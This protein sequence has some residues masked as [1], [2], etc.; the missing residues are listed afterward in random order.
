MSVDHS[1]SLLCIGGN[2]AVV[3]QCLDDKQSS[4]YYDH[5]DTKS[6]PG[7]YKHHMDRCGKV[8][9]MDVHMAK[10]YHTLHDNGEWDP[11]RSFGGNIQVYPS[12]A[13]FHKDSQVR[14]RVTLGNVRVANLAD[15]NFS[16]R[17]EH[18]S[19]K[20]GCRVLHN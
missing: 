4:W 19:R 5:S 18:H 17:S 16:G 15:D 1:A 9:H 8:S 11:R 3:R 14:C 7:A 13:S 6:E 20:D 10:V 12:T 2:T